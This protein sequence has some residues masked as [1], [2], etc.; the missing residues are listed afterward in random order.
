MVATGE[1]GWLAGEVQLREKLGTLYGA[2]NGYEGRPSKS[3]LDRVTVL[4]DELAKAE[5]EFAGLVSRDID[6]VNRDLAGRKLPPLRVLPL[7]E[8][9]KK[10][11]GGATA[12]P[13][14]GMPAFLPLSIFL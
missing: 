5:K 3:Q 9:K 11:S 14:A 10:D 7:E 4:A 6:E 2:V 13:A 12:P 8:W 1:A